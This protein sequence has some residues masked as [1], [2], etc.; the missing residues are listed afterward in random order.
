MVDALDS[1][2]SD[3]DG[4]DSTLPPPPP[5]LVMPPPPLDFTLHPPPPKFGFPQELSG[6]ADLLDAANALG[7][8]PMTSQ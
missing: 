1:I 5:G 4:D 6:D 2:E 8:L 7:D 3:S